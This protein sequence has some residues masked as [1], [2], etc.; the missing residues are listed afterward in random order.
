M[1]MYRE[2]LIGE[3]I[4]LVLDHIQDADP[5]RGWVPAYCFWI[6]DKQ[7]NKM[8]VCDLRVG[9]TEG[10]YYG[11]NIGYTVQKEYRGHHYAAKA[12]RLLFDLARRHDLGYLYITCRPNNI[13]SRKT[14]EALGG[15]LVEIV[16][17][18]EGHD[19]RRDDG[20][21][22]ECIYRFEL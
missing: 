11:G 14:C 12:C 15:R 13:P 7:G 21:T 17:L 1:E 20:H 10:L 2:D 9:H 4:A 18:P 3:E 19:L 16:E 22:H 8:G 5:E 6:C